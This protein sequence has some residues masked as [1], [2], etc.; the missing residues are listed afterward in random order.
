LRADLALVE[1]GLCTS[2]A[3][4]QALIEA[5]KVFVRFGSQPAQAVRKASQAI[6]AFNTIE[7]QN[8]DP[9]FVSRGGIKL[10]G[11]LDYT[12]L[13][14][15]GFR[16]GDFGQST[17]G[18]TDCL[19]QRGAKSVVGFDVGKEQLHPTL[20]AKPEVLAFEGINLKDLDCALW[21]SKLNQNHSNWM[22][23]DLAVADLSFISLKRVLPSLAPFLN[24]G[25]LGLFLVKPQ[26][27]LGPEYLGKNGLVK[28]PEKWVDKLQTEVSATCLEVGLQ[29]ENF[30][31]CT[32]QGG[33]GNQEYFV[34]VRKQ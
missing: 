22:P 16:C 7:V 29:V 18:F 15:D 24:Q 32:I 23:L 25:K 11:A 4:A 34:L 8:P 19:L 5:G 6:E 17:G 1:R 33:D 2:R 10:A 31:P 28:T 14:V 30:F 12:G 9:V 3:Q 26:F 27:E 20:R 21:L 13:K